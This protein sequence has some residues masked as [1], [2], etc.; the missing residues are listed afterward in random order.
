MFRNARRGSTG[1]GALIAVAVVIAGY[2]G[3]A[4]LMWKSYR[5]AGATDTVQRCEVACAQVTAAI[6]G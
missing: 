1:L 6:P 2:L 3:T 4:G 5:D